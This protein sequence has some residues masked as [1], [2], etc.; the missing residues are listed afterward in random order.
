[1]VYLVDLIEMEDTRITNPGNYYGPEVSSFGVVMDNRDEETHTPETE[2]EYKKR[3]KKKE[4]QLDP[5]IGPASNSSN[6]SNS[7]VTE[8]EYK[9]Y[10]NYVTSL[11]LEEQSMEITPE[12]EKELESFS[13]DSVTKGIEVEKEHTTNH[14]IAMKIA[15]DHLKENPSYYEK[16]KA[17]EGDAPY[18]DRMS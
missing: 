6:A 4:K 1:M 11:L 14:R 13:K 18:A 8:A 9:R 2:E 10:I 3:K 12:E 15:L 5:N 17:V 7:E 16:L